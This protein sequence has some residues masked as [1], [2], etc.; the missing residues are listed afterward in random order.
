MFK[1]NSDIDRRITKSKQALRAALLSL[2]QSKEFKKITITDIVQAANLNRGTF[3]K[4]YE[5]KEDILD[6]I[7]DD[8]ISDLIASYRE[9]YQNTEVFE[10]K[11]L[12]SSA[13]KIF[14]HISNNRE[15]Y[16]LILKSNTLSG[17]QQKLC[18]VLKGLTLEDLKGDLP[19]PKINR[20]LQVSF[21]VHALFGMIT[22]WINEGFKYSSD[23]MAEQLLEIIKSKQTDSVYTFT[24]SER[25]E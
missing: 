13:I 16:T 5:Y 21:Y 8:V 19:N 14:E 20:E 3:Y 12:T 25:N 23:Y 17:L 9:P 6:E 10:V 15:F 22:E 11:S 18:N 7:I 4:H 24:Y 1:N 2:M